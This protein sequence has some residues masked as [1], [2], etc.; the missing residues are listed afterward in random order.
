MVFILGIFIGTMVPGKPFS[1]SLF[2]ND[3]GGH[4]LQLIYNRLLLVI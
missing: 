3:V 4:D 1:H 2:E